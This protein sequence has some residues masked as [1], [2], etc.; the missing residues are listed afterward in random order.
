MI[1][2]LKTFMPSMSS[3]TSDNDNNNTDNNI[4]MLSSNEMNS[5][6][7]NCSSA[8]EL[9]HVDEEVRNI[10]ANNELRGGDIKH[11]ITRFVVDSLHE[12]LSYLKDEIT[13]LRAESES[14]NNTIKRLLEE[15]SDSRKKSQRKMSISESS[16]MLNKLLTILCH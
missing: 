13:F 8:H 4:L 6:R 5:N 14:K 12:Q 7:T 1:V 15:L 11:D 3:N 9:S 16:L 10:M 2:K